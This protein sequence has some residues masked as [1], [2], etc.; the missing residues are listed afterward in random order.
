MPTR[1]RFLRACADGGGEDAIGLYGQR[2]GRRRSSGLDDSLARSAWREESQ[3]AEHIFISLIISST[4][5]EI[6]IRI[7]AKDPLHNLSLANRQR[8]HF[9][10]LLPNKHFDGFLMNEVV[11]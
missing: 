6:G 3:R 11:L 4:K 5:D 1:E 2:D 7:M 9:K 10:I 8:P